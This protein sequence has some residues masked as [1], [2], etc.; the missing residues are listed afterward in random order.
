M[1]RPSS[2]LI[3]AALGTAMTATTL[4]AQ[5]SPSP[6]GSGTPVPYSSAM[7]ASRGAHHL[8]RNAWD[9]LEYQEYDRALA[10]FREA[11]ARKNELNDQQKLQLAQGIDR[12]RRGLREAANAS[13]PSYARSGSLPRPGAL[14][15]A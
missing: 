9:Y 1:S 15:L 5:Q 2:A 13:R 11:E 8:L 3:T 7:M 14:A 6:P 10:L 12:A 4:I